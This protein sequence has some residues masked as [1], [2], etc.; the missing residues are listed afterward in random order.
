MREI[1]KYPNPILATKTKEVIEFDNC[2]H[3][4]LNDLKNCLIKH[5]ALGI[6]ANQ[7]GEDK[8][9]FIMKAQCVFKEGQ[10]EIIEFINPKIIDKSMHQRMNTTEGCLSAPGI[11]LTIPRHEEIYVQYQDRYGNIKEGILNGIE[12]ICFQHELD[13]LQGIF[14]I[15]KAS[16]NER[17]AALK[18]LGLR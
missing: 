9:L 18:I 2:L 1:V 5:N 7:I 12:S 13:H 16:R 8:S 11:I 17:R 3:D 14:F 10:G 15:D 6:A 4:L